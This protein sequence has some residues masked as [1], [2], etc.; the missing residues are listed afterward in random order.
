MFG[1]G[2]L[3]MC[4]IVLVVLIFIRPEDL[5]GFIRKVG[6]FYGQAT[7]AYQVI[8]RNLR[9]SENQF[10]QEVNKSVDWVNNSSELESV[11]STPATPIKKVAKS[12][13]K[14]TTKKTTP[15]VPSKS[16]TSSLNSKAKS[17]KPKSS[18]TKK[19][20]LAPKSA[21]K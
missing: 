11:Q 18:L 15:K 4:L 3:E 20:N 12:K 5:P 17:P 19:K 9:D 2:F 6:Q 21:K 8:W 13:Q 7:E 16:N 10:K 1:L 14:K